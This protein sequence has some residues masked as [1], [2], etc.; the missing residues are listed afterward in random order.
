M[1]TDIQ[2]YV[3]QC[4][5]FQRNKNENISSPGL[6][7]PLHTPNQKWEISI[8]FIEGLPMS[9]GNEKILVVVNKLPNMYI[10]LD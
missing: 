4:D 2:K 3:A 1:N 7:H 8:D 5:I 10:L 9:D 6:L